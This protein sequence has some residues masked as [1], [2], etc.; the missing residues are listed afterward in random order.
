VAAEQERLVVR[1]GDDVA[2]EPVLAAIESAKQ[3]RAGTAQGG[4]TR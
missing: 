4:T 3:V 1:C 2:S